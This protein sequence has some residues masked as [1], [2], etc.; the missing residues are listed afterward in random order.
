MARVWDYLTMLGLASGKESED[1]KTESTVK[2]G[3]CLTDYEIP[4]S[5]IPILQAI[6]ASLPEIDLKDRRGAT[7]YI[8]F[9]QVSD[10]PVDCHLARGVDVFKRTFLAFKVLVEQK[11]ECVMTLFQRYTDTLLPWVTAGPIKLCGAMDDAKWQDLSTLLTTGKLV[12][13]SKNI[14]TKHIS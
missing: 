2:F 8:D 3:P 1:G 14:S 11:E 12:V 13:H 7:D 6:L 10:L 4:L 5:K 9:I